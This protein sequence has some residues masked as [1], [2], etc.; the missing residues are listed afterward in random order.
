MDRVR[1]EPFLIPYKIWECSLSVMAQIIK[2]SSFFGSD[3]ESTI[4]KDRNILFSRDWLR[5]Y[6][7]VYKLATTFD[8][9]EDQIKGN[10]DLF[11][12]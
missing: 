4:C 11:Q 9:P 2:L 6:L 12:D 3:G 7:A 10:V 1:V 5:I 8:L